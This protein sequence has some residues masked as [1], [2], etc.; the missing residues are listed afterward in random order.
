MVSFICFGNQSAERNNQTFPLIADKHYH[1]YL[2]V[3]RNRTV[4]LLVIGSVLLVDVNLTIME[5][6]LQQHL[7]IMN[8]YSEVMVT[9]TLN[10]T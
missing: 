9:V 7:L 2:T 5:S 6:W 10:K 8:R 4:K 3:D 1:I